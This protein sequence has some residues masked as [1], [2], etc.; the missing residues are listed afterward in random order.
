MSGRHLSPMW[1][2]AN[3]WGLRFNAISKESNTWLGAKTKVLPQK[4]AFWGLRGNPT[5]LLHRFMCD[6]KECTTTGWGSSFWDLLYFACVVVVHSSLGQRLIRHEWEVSLPDVG[7]NKSLRTKAQRH[8]PKRTIPDWGP[9]RKSSHTYNYKLII[10]TMSIK[11][12]Y[13]DI[14]LQNCTKY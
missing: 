11:F 13:Y 3:P 8:F 4:G 14:Y 7:L 10:T 5:F 6:P 2:W 1:D 9:R 12:K